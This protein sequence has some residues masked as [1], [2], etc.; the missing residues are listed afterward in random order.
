MLVLR[1]KYSKP[2]MDSSAML[3]SGIQIAEGIG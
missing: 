1:V 2:D 3:T